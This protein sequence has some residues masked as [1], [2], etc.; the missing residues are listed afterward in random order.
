MYLSVYCGTFLLPHTSTKQKFSK[1][2]PVTCCTLCCTNRKDRCKEKS[3]F[4]IPAEVDQR[5]KWIAAINRKDW[6][7]T[8]YY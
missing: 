2:I 7:P 4:R 6:Q 1:K 5:Q 8:E 3:F